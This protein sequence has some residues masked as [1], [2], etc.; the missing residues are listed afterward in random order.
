M[1]NPFSKFVHLYHPIVNN[2]HSGIKT[3]NLAIG[4]KR[5]RREDS[6][7]DLSDSEVIEIPSTKKFKLDGTLNYVY[8]TLYLE[9]KDSDILVIA[10]DKLWK[11]HKVYLCQSPY[12]ESMF[13][14]SWRESND[15]V[16][17][18]EICDP[19][20]TQNSLHV[21]FG[22]LY[23]HEMT[24]EAVSPIEVLA[25]ASHFQLEY[26]IDQCASYMIETISIKTVVDYYE[27]SLKYGVAVVRDKC[28]NWM[29]NNL[30]RFC[31]KS[32]HAVPALHALRSISVDLMEQLVDN[33]KFL[34]TGTESMIVQLLVTWVAVQLNP[35]WTGSLQTVD[36]KMIPR[37]E[38]GEAFLLTDTGQQYAPAFKALR[39]KHL[40]RLSFFYKNLLSDNIIPTSW[41]EPHIIENWSKLLSVYGGYETGPSPNSVPE[42]VFERESMRFGRSL[43]DATN[44]YVWKWFPFSFGIGVYW[45]WLLGKLTVSRMSHNA[46]QSNRIVNMV[47]KWKLML[48]VS[49]YCSNP[50]GELVF[51][52]TSGIQSV[53]LNIDASEVN[54]ELGLNNTKLS[55]PVFLL[56][57]VLVVS[58]SA[59][60]ED[61]GNNSDV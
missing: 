53:V 48:R 51:V 3:F 56:V 38:S 32:T 34:F 42:E 50:K 11:L 17:R 57:Q 19:N 43:P 24:F 1:G 59:S 30:T 25:T 13:S 46:T 61:S 49:V 28:F 7:S 10:L 27:A 8:K 21:V 45:D 39:L 4:R 23:L 29:L 5:K 12:F 40:T 47:E 20:I 31:S 26:L 14:G 58:P 35:D 37:D 2:I 55:Y 41:L 52:S 22:C 16:V 60:A 54:V 6:D 33:S 15:R 9:G 18:I 44:Q 36:Q